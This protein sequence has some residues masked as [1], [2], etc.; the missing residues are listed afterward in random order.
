MTDQG[1]DLLKGSQSLI[2]T[3][4]VEST[5]IGMIFIRCKDGVSHHPAESTTEEDALTGARLLL[6]FLQ[7]FNKQL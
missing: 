7:N 6:N 4:M 1:A 3:A 5:E 2:K